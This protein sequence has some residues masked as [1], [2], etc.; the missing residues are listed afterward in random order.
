MATQVFPT[1]NVDKLY[2]AKIQENS[3]GI[4]SFDTPRYLPGVRS[5]GLKISINSEPFYAEGVKWDS[6]ESFESVEAEIDIVDITAEDEAYILGHE[7]AEG[8]GVIYN[9]NDKA[10][11]IAM[12]FRAKKSNKKFR[13]MTLFRGKFID[14]DEDYQ[15]KEGKTNFQTRKLV[16]T[17][18][19]LKSNGMWKHKKDEEEG[20][21]DSWFTSVTIPTKKDS[22]L[23]E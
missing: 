5:I 17:F 4:E 18:A 2:V 3:K 12:L 6:D 14:S 8:G 16:G 20:A 11:E 15:Q 1:V 9:E 21:T 13:Y 22:N 7:L 23:S 19:P 10:P